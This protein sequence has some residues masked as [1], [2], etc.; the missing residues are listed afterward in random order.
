MGLT[1]HGAISCGGTTRLVRAADGWFAVGLSREDDID[2]VPAWLELDG[3]SSDVWSDVE[4]VA[5]QR[6]VDYL[7]ARGVLVGLPVAA[8]RGTESPALASSPADVTPY[9]M[10]RRAERPPVVV[11]LSSLWAGPLCSHL[12]ERN[13]ARVIKVESAHRPDGAR[14]GSP[15]FFDLL[16]QGKQSVLLDLRTTDGRGTFRRLIASAD[17]V[18]EASRPRAL[19]QL[20]VI[21][22]ELL[23][24]E[25][26]PDVWISITGYGRAGDA[27]R[28]VA[29]GDDA[30]VG[31]GLVVYDDLGPCFCVDA[32]ADPLTGMVA[33]ATALDLLHRG[34]QRSLVDIA[35]AKVAGHFAGPTLD[36]GH[37]ALSAAPPRAG[38]AESKAAPPGRDTRAVLEELAI[39]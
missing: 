29:F 34:R 23:R 3:P 20:G 12:L 33:A 10:R 26:G 21:A 36:A 4:A 25:S 14:T 27:G 32:I 9:G 37:I 2:A 17:V 18:I 22:D 1:R 30:A 8:L 11:D 15:R 28:R 38:V 6:P 35:M 31:G 24:D 13:G 7:E 19:E 39:G 5:L 16:N